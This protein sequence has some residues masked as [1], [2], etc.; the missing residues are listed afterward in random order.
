MIYYLNQNT[1]PTIPTPHDCK[2]KKVTIRDDF[3]IF[4]FEDDISYCDSIRH[5][6]P[7]AKSLVIKIHLVDTFDTYKMKYYKKPWCRG[8]YSRIDNAK[9]E[10]MALNEGLE[11][12]EHYVGYQSIIIKLFGQTEIALDIV[13]DYIEY[14]WIV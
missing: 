10:K 7:D 12:I 6:N 2:I 4:E 11:Y 3:I 14:E 13:T 1:V 8:D 5:F 9:L